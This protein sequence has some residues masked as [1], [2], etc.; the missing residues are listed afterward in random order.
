M[1]DLK[2]QLNA[3]QHEAVTSIDGPVLVIAGAGSGK[4]RV[5][6]Y[7]VLHLVQSGI[8]PNSILLLTFTRKAAK[9]MLSR[10]AR[11]DP[12]CKNVEGGTFHSFAYRQLRKYGHAIGLAGSF[13]VLD[14]GDAEEAIHRCCTHLGIFEKEKRFPRKDTLK[15]IIS[16][17]INKH[18]PISEILK[19]EYPH[20][21]EFSENIEEIRRQYARYKLA[22]NYLDYDDLLLYL[23]ILLDQETIRERLSDKYLYVMVDEYQDTNRLQGEIAFLL[24]ERRRNIMIV[25]DDAQSIYGFRGGSHR[26]I[27]EFPV[28]FPEYR[29]IKLEENYRSTQAIL[30]VANTVMENMK[31]KYSK[32]LT[33]ARKYSGNKPNVLFFR[34]IHEEAE[35]VARMIKEFRDEGV[36]L[37]H[38]AVLFRSAYLSIP[39]QAEL[40]R[41][42]I[43]YQVFGGMKFYETAHVK[44]V[45]AHLKLLVNPKDE[46]AWNRVLMIIE[47]IGP[48][49]AEKLAGEILG[50]G[51]FRDIREHLLKYGE[52]RRFSEGLVKLESLLNMTCDE[53]LDVGEKFGAVIGYY[54]PLLR[55]RHDDWHL[56]LNDLDALRQIAMRYSS[57]EELLIDF[58]IEPPEKGVWRVEP[59][60]KDEE[61]PLTLSTIHSAKGLE[62]DSVF[63]I[64]LMDGVLP[65]SFALDH[66]DEIEEEHRLFYVGITRAKNQLFLVCHHEGKRGGLNQFNK[67]SRFID[68]PNV[69]ARLEKK[70]LMTG[71]GEEGAGRAED[72]L[73][74]VMDRDSLLKKIGEY[75]K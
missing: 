27:M 60:T 62:W 10:A 28:R 3:A 49:T 44:D 32:C 33:S 71:A 46:L 55:Q 47:G 58:A 59:E 16:M 29:L 53:A 70:G 63:L 15:A 40:A 74:P 23:R 67:V 9:E 21:L 72:S 61:K 7:R 73:L 56:R 75:L 2:E 48:K 36:D 37:G 20:F 65:V 13:S 50:K 8:T 12:R 51:S 4:T 25:G 5:I 18:V 14:E 41:R 38:Q 45:M 35:W 34:D 17:S 26:N 69:A 54:T 68:V 66:E 22:K 57:V 64:G 43:P 19:K 24:A 30:D 1:I 42:N 39:L 31:E 6:E 52:G 11:H